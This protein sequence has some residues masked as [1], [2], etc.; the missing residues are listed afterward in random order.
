[1]LLLLT[2]ATGFGRAHLESGRLGCSLHFILVKRQ[3]LFPAT[4][5]IINLQNALPVLCN[6]GLVLPLCSSVCLMENGGDTGTLL[7]GRWV[8]DDHWEA[9][10]TGRLPYML[11]AVAAKEEEEEHLRWHVFVKLNSSVGHWWGHSQ[12]PDALALS[13]CSDHSYD[14]WLKCLFVMPRV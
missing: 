5:P 10:C 3:E 12:S 9:G 7:V 11:T 4:F 1:M 2:L 14:L 6:L 13:E 8:Q